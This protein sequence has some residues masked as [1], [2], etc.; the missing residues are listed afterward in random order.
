MAERT[1]PC[2]VKTKI[3]RIAGE[4][5]GVRVAREAKFVGMKLALNPLAIDSAVLMVS[6]PAVGSTPTS[7]VM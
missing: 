7:G 2:V 3:F 6:C 1:L 4:P 5:G